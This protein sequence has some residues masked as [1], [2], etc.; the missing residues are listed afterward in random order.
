MERRVCNFSELQVDR[1]VKVDIDGVPVVVVRDARDEVHAI[2]DTCTHADIS[3]SEGFF[4]GET[5][6]CWAHGA[7]FDVTTGAAISLP[8]FDPVPV[9]QVSVV[10]G[11][12]YVDPTGTK[13]GPRAGAG[14]MLSHHLG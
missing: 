5:I 1:P 4:E 2:G 3:L 9:Y 14:E 7:Q 10:D 8:A 12:V 6:E 11:V 13:E